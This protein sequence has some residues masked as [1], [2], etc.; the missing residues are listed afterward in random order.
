MR[1]NRMGGAAHRGRWHI[2][3][4]RPPAAPNAVNDRRRI[5]TAHMSVANL[6]Y[7]S[8]IDFEQNLSVATESDKKT[9]RP[10]STTPWA[11]IVENTI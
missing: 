1:G 10:T 2:V 5:H 9:A 7:L 11:P 3:A 4:A 6:A 8:P